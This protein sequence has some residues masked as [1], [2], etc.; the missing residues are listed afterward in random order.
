MGDHPLY[1]RF[2]NGE[3]RHGVYRSSVDRALPELF[4]TREA[5]DAAHWR[6]GERCDYDEA[7]DGPSEPVEIAT[8]YGGGF[9]WAG[10]ATRDWIASGRDPFDDVHSE[11]TPRWLAEHFADGILQLAGAVAEAVPPWLPHPI[12]G[13]PASP[14]H[15]RVLDAYCAELD[16]DP[17]AARHS[18]M[19]MME[20]VRWWNS[21]APELYKGPTAAGEALVKYREAIAAGVDEA[22]PEYWAMLTRDDRRERLARVMPDPA[23]PGWQAPRSKHAP[24]VRERDDD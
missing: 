2:A 11:G 23:R 13:E 21:G 9:Y 20:S 14:T 4:R 22:D 16:I 3:I 18:W 10:R 19:T 12:P 6:H 7:M 15:L 17:E 24:A 8:S 1:V 5:G